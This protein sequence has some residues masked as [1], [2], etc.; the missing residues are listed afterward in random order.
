MRTVFVSTGSHIW[1]TNYRILGLARNAH[2]LGLDAHV[3]LPDLPANRKWFP[4]G[5]YEGVPIHF[6]GSGPLSEPRSKYELLRWL[7]PRVVHCAGVIKPCFPAAAA[8]RA[9]H[10]CELIVD[11]DEHLSRIKMHGKARR[12]YYVFTEN[13]ARRYADRLVVA[14][15]FLERWFGQPKR[16][17]VLYL[18]NA[19]ELDLF[20][21]QQSGWQELKAR[22]GERKVVTYFGALSPH[23]DADM[24]FDAAVKMLARRQDLVFVF[25]GGGEMLSP[26][27]ER[28]RLAGL[29]DAIQ[30]CGFVPDEVVPQY[31]CAADALVFPIRDNWWNRARCPGKVYYFAAATAPIVT[32]PVGEVHEALSDHAW[33]FK[34]G[35][36]DDLIRV[37]E[38]CLATGRDGCCPDETLAS[39]HSWRARAE[40]YLEF[41]DGD[42]GVTLRP[43]V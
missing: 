39:R 41:L 36:I 9:N 20:R 35:D 17:P 8:Y 13:V 11:F 31:L 10:A 27:R 21:R 5:H 18:P 34:D 16:Q 1:G 6:T 28:A 30:F 25:I 14:S 4:D 2:Q 23:Y 33:Y 38:Q 29:Q 43:A 19:V 22:W 15:R 12:L 32:N 37:L 24:V 3:L 42:L 40:S 7:R 26:F